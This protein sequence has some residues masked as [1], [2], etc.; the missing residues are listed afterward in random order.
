MAG[1]LNAPSQRPHGECNREVVKH[2]ATRLRCSA[3]FNNN[4]EQSICC[5]LLL[6]I[7]AEDSKTITDSFV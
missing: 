4:D 7:L 5:G 3:H 1:V 6:E 2:I